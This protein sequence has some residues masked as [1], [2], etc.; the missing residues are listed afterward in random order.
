MIGMVEAVPWTYI[1]PTTMSQPSGPAA[2]YAVLCMHMI[3]LCIVWVACVVIPLTVQEMIFHF[4]HSYLSL[5]R[6]SMVI[7]VF[8]SLSEE[9]MLLTYEV[10][11]H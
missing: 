4:F 11:D 10:V 5:M 9:S 6:Y 7:C 3:K 1:A 2:A 8:I